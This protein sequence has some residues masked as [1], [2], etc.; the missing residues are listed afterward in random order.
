MDTLL[1]IQPR[2][3]GDKGAN[4][5]PE[6]LASKIAADIE[7]KLPTE[8]VNKRDDN[9]NSLIIFRSQEIERF[10]KLLKVMRKSLGDL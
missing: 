4:E 3:S 7:A 6:L 1:G 9:P 5:K 10:N 8:I 2:V